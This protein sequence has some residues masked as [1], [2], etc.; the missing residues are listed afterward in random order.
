MFDMAS[1]GVIG[2]GTWG[3]A[4][5]I[6]LAGNGHQVDLWSALE[7]EVAALSRTRIHPNLPK[8][9]IPDSIRVTGNLKEAMED[10]DLLVLSVPSVFVRQTAGRMR[11]FLKP[12]QVVV[13]V[14]K[15]IEE[16]SLMTLSQVIEEELPDCQVAALS[17]PSHA[18]EVSQGLPTTCVAGAHKRHVAELVQSVF[19]SGVFRVYTNPDLLGIE[20][21][22]AICGTDGN[23]R[24]DRHLR[25]HAQPQPQSGN[26]HRPG[27]FHGGG[28]EGG[29]YGGGRRLQRQSGTGTGG[30]ISGFH[31]DRGAGEPGAV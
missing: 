31:A 27:T 10:K 11:E 18:E 29:P 8:A 28:H 7:S 22:G 6:L 20:L 5:S 16:G 26:P 25:Q 13:N 14:A 15:G 23:R 12:G 3:T 21:G 17:G 2:S 19:M 9:R 24:P 30:K 1:I 4:L